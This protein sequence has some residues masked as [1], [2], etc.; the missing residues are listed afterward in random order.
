MQSRAQH[1]GSA[2]GRARGSARDGAGSS[3][4]GR[5]RGSARGRAGSSARGR[6]RG[7]ARE[8]RMSLHEIG[9]WEIRVRVRVGPVGDVKLEQIWAVRGQTA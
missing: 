1:W 6:A 8:S 9:L 5:A 3:V 7:R 2:R 4:R